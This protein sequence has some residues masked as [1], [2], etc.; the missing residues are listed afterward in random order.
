M[1]TIK[2]IFT[3]LIATM[4]TSCGSAS[5]FQVYKT[6][7]SDKI[8]TKDNLLV[9]EDENCKVSYNLWDEGGNVGFQF[10]NKTDKNIYLNLEESFFILNGISH[11]YYKNRV[12]T[13]SASAGSTS[14]SSAN[15][16][17]SISGINYLKLFQSNK[18][19]KTNT[20][21]LI[22]SSASSVA[23][24][25]EKLITIPSKTSKV[26]SE[27]N[28]NASLFRNC[29]LYKYPTKKQIKTKTFSKTQS[30]I[31]FSNR[32]AYSIEQTESLIKFENEFYV[33][34]I[35]NYPESEMF[36]FKKEEYCGEKSIIK[37]KFFKNAS[38]E[39]FYIKYNK[40]QDTSKH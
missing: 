30:P 33:T 13:N 36:V 39:K 19:S 27:Y 16:T 4:L 32:I 26:I 11:N 21:G 37:S 5:Y 24:N 7:T 20:V 23:Y 18:I 35:S 6:E 8:I 9:Y 2:I 14:S 40:G 28:I 1:K 25:E 38:A 31:V 17:K 12:F 10:F 3:A 29:D 22:T 15:S 34:E